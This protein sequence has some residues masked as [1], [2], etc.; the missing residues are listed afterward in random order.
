MVLESNLSPHKQIV[1]DYYV[2]VCISIEEMEKLKGFI[3]FF[4]IM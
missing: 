1:M 2:K 4:K 3:F